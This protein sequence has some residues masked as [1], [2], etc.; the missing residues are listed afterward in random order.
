MHTVGLSRLSAVLQQD[1]FPCKV[2]YVCFEMQLACS[3]LFY[4]VRGTAE[5]LDI[6]VTCSGPPLP[7]RCSGRPPR[8]GHCSISD[9]LPGACLVTASEHPVPS[10]CHPAPQPLPPGDHQFVLCVSEFLL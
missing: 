6:H 3:I 4:Q 2:L 10:L 8:R 5:Q 9:H 7:A 1:L